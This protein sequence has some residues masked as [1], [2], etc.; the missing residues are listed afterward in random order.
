MHFRFQLHI[1]EA[2]YWD[3][4]YHLNDSYKYIQI[5]KFRRRVLYKVTCTTCN[6]IKIRFLNKKIKKNKKI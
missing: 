6:L 3:H 2:L 4:E 1:L 5:E